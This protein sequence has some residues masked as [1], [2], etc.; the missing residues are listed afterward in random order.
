[1][2]GACVRACVCVRER[3]CV[4]VGVSVSVS[5]PCVCACVRLCVCV[6][7]SSFVRVVSQRVS[8]RTCRPRL[9]ART[10]QIPPVPDR[11]VDPLRLTPLLVSCNVFGSSHCAL[12][13]VKKCKRR[14]AN[15]CT[16]PL[17]TDPF[18]MSWLSASDR[19]HR[20]PDDVRSGS[21]HLTAGTPQAPTN[22]LA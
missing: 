15:C 21:A 4:S 13:Q 10:Q 8:T 12:A 3:E 17:G 2:C 22:Q 18:Y 11:C 1:V 16:D 14:S 5:V 19:I 7:A 20:T 6:C 9:R